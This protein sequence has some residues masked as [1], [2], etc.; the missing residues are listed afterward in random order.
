MCCTNVWTGLTKYHEQNTHDPGVILSVFGSF[1]GHIAPLRNNMK[2][3][4]KVNIIGNS[5]PETGEKVNNFIE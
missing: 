1:M 4:G 2:F 5:K 3:L